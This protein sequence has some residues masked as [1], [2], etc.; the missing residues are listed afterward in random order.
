ME[1]RKLL[2][3]LLE[4]FETVGDNYPD[5][6]PISIIVKKVVEKEAPDKTFTQWL[7]GISPEKKREHSL[8]HFKNEV[9]RLFPIIQR[10]MY[11][12][13]VNKKFIEPIKMGGDFH[14]VCLKDPKEIAYRI[15]RQRRII[16]GHY[17]RL[18]RLLKL[19]VEKLTVEAIEKLND[20]ERE[21]LEKVVYAEMTVPEFVKKKKKEGETTEQEK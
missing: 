6:I 11:E 16:E 2:K 5:G 4:I 14:Y 21:M 20:E 7:N 10:I 13:N 3:E 12:R 8:A 15:E 17:P 18:E 19:G 9:R 1:R